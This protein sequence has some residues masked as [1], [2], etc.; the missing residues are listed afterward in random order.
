MPYQV[1][2]MLVNGCPGCKDQSLLLLDNK[3]QVH[4]HAIV[5]AFVRGGRTR[6]GLWWLQ[7]YL[8]AFK[9]V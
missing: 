3:T 2:A 5:V 7:A 8:H 6:G 1:N 9:D 4:V